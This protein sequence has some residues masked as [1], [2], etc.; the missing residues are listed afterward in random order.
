MLTDV[1]HWTGSVIARSW[2]MDFTPCIR[3]PDCMTRN[4]GSSLVGIQVATYRIVLEQMHD[5]RLGF[6]I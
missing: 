3:G 2:V 4:F 1:I 6:D 5:V